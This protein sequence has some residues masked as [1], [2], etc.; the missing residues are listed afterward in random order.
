MD[1]DLGGATVE[2]AADRV[3]HYV[4]LSEGLANRH[5]QSLYIGQLLRFG[6]IYLASGDLRGLV[7]ELIRRKVPH[8]IVDFCNNSSLPVVQRPRVSHYRHETIPALI[9]HFAEGTNICVDDSRKVIESFEELMYARIYGAH[10]VELIDPYFLS[11][12]SKR[13]TKAFLRWLSRN[14]SS[15]E[16][17]RVFAVRT[18]FVR[19]SKIA[20]GKPIGE[21]EAKAQWQSIT[22]QFRA[23]RLDFALE[24]H[25]RESSQADHDRYLMI[26]RS[27][28]GPNALPNDVFALSSGPG[29][30]NKK[31]TLAVSR[32]RADAWNSAGSR[33][34]LSGYTLADC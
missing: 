7:G 1:I 34:L 6:V 32:V 16:R 28:S 15:G 4:R 11:N 8:D 21:A 17:Q 30:W 31:G 23:D 5:L 3:E 13:G 29:R 25:L 9:R 22:R 10:R 12:P 2:Q 26:Q 24:L 18:C 27:L 14:V 33:G 19:D 20:H